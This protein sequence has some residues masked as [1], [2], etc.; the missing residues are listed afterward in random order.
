MF[1]DI[2]IISFLQS[3]HYQPDIYPQVNGDMAACTQ[4]QWFKGESPEPLLISLQDGFVATKKEFVVDKKEL[5]DENIFEV[6]KQS[7][8]KRE[9]DVRIIFLLGNQCSLIRSLIIQ[10][11]EFLFFLYRAML[12][13][14]PPLQHIRR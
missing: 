10:L 5:K 13:N 1:K 7:A 2:F 6:N 12:H 4:D 11:L 8:P 9:E 3:D 14:Q